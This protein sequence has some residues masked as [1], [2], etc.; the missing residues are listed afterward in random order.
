MSDVESALRAANVETLDARGLMP[1]TRAREVLSA[2][3]IVDRDTLDQVWAAMLSLA[4]AEELVEATRHLDWQ[5][6]VRGMEN[7]ALVERYGSGAQPTNLAPSRRNLA[8]G[9]PTARRAQRRK[10]HFAPGDS[11]QMW[12]MGSTR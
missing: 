9:P 7:L 10:E 11:H 1:I 3:T 2:A 6:P 12:V 5:H 8:N 4:T